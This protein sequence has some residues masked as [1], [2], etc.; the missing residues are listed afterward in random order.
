MELRQ[1]SVF[2]VLVIVKN[3]RVKVYVFNAL[4]GIM[5]LM[6]LV[7]NA[8]KYAQLVL[9]KGK[10]IVQTVQII[11]FGIEVQINVRNAILAVQYVRK[12]Y[13]RVV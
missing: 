8:M 7:V 12:I 5:L 2:I 1:D 9:V 13:V 3:V 4:M 6:V 11:T 10:T